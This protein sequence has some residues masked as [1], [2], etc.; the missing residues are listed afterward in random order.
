M[1][2]LEEAG[3]NVEGGRHEDLCVETDE[4][5]TDLERESKI[6]MFLT[7]ML[8]YLVWMV[9]MFDVYM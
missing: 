9:D 1:E 5:G 3:Q 7:V 2:R 8:Q 6:M 4:T